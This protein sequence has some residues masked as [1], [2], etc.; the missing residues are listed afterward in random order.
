MNNIKG[1]KSV[2]FGILASGHGVV[3][4]NGTLNKSSKLVISGNEIT[5]INNN[6]MVPKI[7]NGKMYISS[8]C[9]RHFLF[10]DE[11]NAIFLSEQGLSNAKDN[12]ELLRKKLLKIIGSSIGLV[13]GFM[14]TCEGSGTEGVSRRSALQIIDFKETKGE[15]NAFEQHT[16]SYGVDK[17]N[18]KDKNSIFSKT[19]FGETQYESCGSLSI[20]QL[21]FINLTQD[22]NKSAFPLSRLAEERYGQINEI[23]KSINEYLSKINQFMGLE[24]SPNAEHGIYQRR[25]QLVDYAQEGFLL[26]DDAIDCLVS[27]FI[28]KIENFSIEKS[29]AFMQI[30][31]VNVVYNE[32]VRRHRFSDMI[33]SIDK[34]SYYAKYYEKVTA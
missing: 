11:A 6:H 30:D 21:Q 31:T 28:Y 4:W 23:S 15:V 34:K 26:N 9:I 33:D 16:N 22:L 12:D 7:R 20:E 2:D 13:R 5:A 32:T 8:S 17:N 24:L 10:H 29:D 25:N 27:Y 1:I 14:E 18:K 3:N 19:T